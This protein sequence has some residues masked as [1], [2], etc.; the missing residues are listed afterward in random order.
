M[1]KTE[2]SNAKAPPWKEILKCILDVWAALPS[3]L[4]KES[5]IHCASSLRLTNQVMILLIASEKD[6]RAFKVMKFCI[7]NIWFC[8][9]KKI[10][11]DH[12]SW[13]EED[14]E[15]IDISWI[16]YRLFY[17]IFWRKIIHVEN[18]IFWTG[19]ALD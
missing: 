1:N 7:C 16:I 6:S 4:I 3:E 12:P 13:D 18:I 15:G 5:F 17:S 19:A 14:D 2:A 9:M 10:E 11:D 8:K